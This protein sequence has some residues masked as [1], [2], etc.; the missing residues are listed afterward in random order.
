MPNSAAVQ[1]ALVDEQLGKPYIAYL[2]DEHRIDWNTLS[3]SGPVYSAMPLTF[4]IISGGSINWLGRG[5]TSAHTIEYKVNDG[6][7]TSFGGNLGQYIEVEAGDIVQ[8]RGDHAAYGGAQGFPVSG[9]FSYYTVLKDPVATYKAYGNVMSLISS[10]GFTELS[11]F[12]AQKALC[13]LFSGGSFI[14]GYEFPHGLVD[15]E[16]LVLPATTLSSYCYANMFRG[17]AALTKAPALPA[18]TLA[19]NCYATMFS[20]CTALTTAPELPATALSNY[21]YLAMFAGCTSLTTAPELPATTLSSYCYQRMF[22][23]CTN[24]NYI[25]ALF[26]TAPTASTS[27]PTYSWV[28]GVASTGTFVKNSAATWNVTG[29]NGVPTNWTVQEATE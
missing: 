2:E 7:W 20:D 23:G 24:L 27:G 25:K 17:C 21:C 6:E 15:A 28:A 22:S 12:T 8:F 10:T 26:T 13:G 18:T 11:A 9:S 19:I 1:T 4:E 29:N 14:S 3:P 5:S 16:N